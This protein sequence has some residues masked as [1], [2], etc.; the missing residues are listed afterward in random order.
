MAPIDLRP[1]TSPKHVDATDDLEASPP[2]RVGPGTVDGEGHFD[3]RAR[4]GAPAVR[5][6]TVSS[7]ARLGR[8]NAAAGVWP[9]DFGSPTTQAVL[10]VLAFTLWRLVAA[11]FVGLGTDEAY[12]IAVSRELRL[13]Y[14]DHPPMQYWIAHFTALAIGLGR[15]DRLPFIALFTGTSWMM[16]LLTRRL[17]SARAGVWACLALNLAGF[18]TVAAGSW[19]AAGRAARLLPDGRDPGHGRRLV[20]RGRGAAA[21][22]AA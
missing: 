4:G 6:I 16:F 22:V 21:V 3:Q 18:L 5:F 9:I 2:T 11:A 12:T 1:L 19:V 17:F 13:S 15:S 10:V 14:F 8:P 20:R 7:A